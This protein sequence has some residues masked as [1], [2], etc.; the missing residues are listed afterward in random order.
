MCYMNGDYY[1]LF[2][3]TKAT[4]EDFES[5]EDATIRAEELSQEFFFVEIYDKHHNSI[6]SWLNPLFNPAK[7]YKL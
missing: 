1:L 4:R 5:L 2:G 3:N 6:C 7:K